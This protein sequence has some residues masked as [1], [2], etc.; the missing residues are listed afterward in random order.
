MSK[1]RSDSAMEE[2]QNSVIHMA[3]PNSKFVYSFAEQ[4]GLWSAKFVPQFGQ[5]LNLD[6]ALVLRFG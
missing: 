3:K 2:I 6:S 1:N 4:V 5:P